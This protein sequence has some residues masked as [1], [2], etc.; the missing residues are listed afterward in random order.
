MIFPSRLSGVNVKTRLLHDQHPHSM[1]GI[2]RSSPESPARLTLELPMIKQSSRVIAG[3]AM[4]A[5]MFI[6]SCKGVLFHRIKAGFVFMSS[7]LVTYQI[8]RFR[9]SVVSLF[10]GTLLRM[11]LLSVTQ[12]HVSFF[13]A[14]TVSITI[15]SPE[16]VIRHVPNS[17][18]SPACGARIRPASAGNCRGTAD[19]PERWRIVPPKPFPVPAPQRR[20]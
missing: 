5:F 10:P 9:D 4:L 20:A 15:S 19:P 2:V 7:S 1:T 3:N 11:S 12:P 14:R 8:I 18:I 16:S 13:H 6:H 17:A